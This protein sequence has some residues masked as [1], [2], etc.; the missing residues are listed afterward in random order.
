[1]P[2]VSREQIS[3]AKAVPILGYILKNEPDNV[4]RV[5]SAYYLKDHRSLKI[6]NGLW[7]WHSQG[8]GGRTAV[9]YLI[10]V[11]G[12]SFVDAVRRL[13]GGG[14]SYTHITP[15]AKPPPEC[16]HFSLPPRNKDN[17]RAVAYL[18]GR[19][20]DVK[21]I[22]TCIS[23]GA[24]YESARWHNAVFVGRDD[25]GKA[26]YAFLRGSIG[27]F[28]RDAD[29]SDKRFGFTIP[30]ID[31]NSDTAAVFESPVD[32]LSHQTLYPEFEG[33]RLSLGCA[34]LASLKCFLERRSNIKGIV[35][36][37][38][39]DL[40]GNT[41]ANKIAVLPGITAA[42]SLPPNG[43]KDWNDALMA[44]M[45][46]EK[47]SLIGRLENAKVEAAIYDR[48]AGREQVRGGQCL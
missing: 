37:T 32:A 14:V 36:C 48:V 12:Y 5:G 25:K 9:D 43:A 35:T 33:W 7:Y 46:E 15:D 21:H 22:L 27:D 38:D 40:A 18:Q 39:N 3:R 11:R 34:S 29:G 20:I 24:L 23:Q 19:G 26:R 28:R 42:R 17:K 30:P 6:S 41:A 45:R 10:K 2:G 13:A 8:V 16:K 47:P 44:H 31:G 4:M 1:M